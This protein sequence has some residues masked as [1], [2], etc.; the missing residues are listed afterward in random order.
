MALGSG[1]L[2][3]LAVEYMG[4]LLSTGRLQSVTAVPT[5]ALAAQEAAFH[6]VPCALSLVEQPDVMIEQPDVVD[7][8][9]AL[10]YVCGRS[11]APA[12]D[13]RRA[14]EL[15]ESAAR[16]VLLVDDGAVGDGM[17]LDGGV[18]VLLPAAEWEEIA[19]ELDDLFLGDATVWRRPMSGTAGTWQGVGALCDALGVDAHAWHRLHR[20]ARRARAVREPGGPH[21]RRHPVRCATQCACS[22]LVSCVS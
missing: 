2:V 14:Q 6:G 20:P 21:H 18:P 4:R 10:S 8:D 9:A 5:S 13:L 17:G 1:P 12:P 16:V 7:N 15:R 19:E 22:G 3:S 11:T